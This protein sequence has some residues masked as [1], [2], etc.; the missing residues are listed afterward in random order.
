ME[1]DVELPDDDMV[2]ISDD[3]IDQQKID[4]Q[5]IADNHESKD[6]E[7]E[8]GKKVQKRINK[9][10]AERNKA[11][12]ENN[13][14]RTR[15]ESLEKRSVDEDNSKLTLKDDERAA[16]IKKRKMAF[17]DEG[18]YEKAEDLNDELINIRMDQRDRN[19]QKE[20]QERQNTARSNEPAQIPEAQKAWMEDNDWYRSEGNLDK[21]AK[22]D[23]EYLSLVSEGYDPN[24]E[25]IYVELNSR[26]KPVKAREQPIPGNA[27][28]RGEVDANTGPRSKKRFTSSDARLMRE[29]K[30]NPDDPAQRESWLDNKK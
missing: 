5:A 13:E 27:P 9:V 20:N 11:R 21:S 30:L 6:D 23:K 17:M 15:L 26:L 14:L 8:Y 3:N 10:V 4:D 25:E 22:A 12:S 24:D 28:N 2:V 16:D 19:R 29:F 7:G 1:Q 18:E